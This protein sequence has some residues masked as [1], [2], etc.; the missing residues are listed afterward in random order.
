[1][2]NVYVVQEV[3]NRNLMPAQKF[4]ELVLLLPPGNIVL[5]PAPTVRRLIKGLKDY[6]D[7]DYL[8]AMGDPIA[9]GLASAIA[10][11]FNNGKVNFLK[12]DRQERLYYKVK[13]N[14][15]GRK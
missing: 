15:F 2:N 11:D 9:I 12:W 4:G 8:L 14:I 5:S 3:P 13:C 1:M 7:S 10:S 6:N